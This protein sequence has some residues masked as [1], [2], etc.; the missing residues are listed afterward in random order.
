M[1]GNGGWNLGFGGSGANGA[2]LS[3]DPPGCEPID[4]TRN[5]LI[6]LGAGWYHECP[7]TYG[8]RSTLYFPAAADTYEDH[9]DWEDFTV[10]WDALK[11]DEGDTWTVEVIVNLRCEN[12]GT[13]ITPRI[14]TAGTSTQNVAGAAHVS[15]SWGT[16]TLTLDS[17]TGVVTYRL[18]IKRSDLN[19]GVYCT[20]KRRLYAP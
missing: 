12:A 4:R 5:A 18:Q 8:S 17:A 2:V 1:P 10:D 11:G 20:A 9:P 15:T 7:I 19:Y 3:S 16:Q 14:V 6:L 13:T